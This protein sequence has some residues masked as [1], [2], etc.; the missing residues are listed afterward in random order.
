MSGRSTM[1]LHLAPY[2]FRSRICKDM[3]RMIN[4]KLY[5]N[6]KI[7]DSLSVNDPFALITLGI[8]FL[9]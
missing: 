3:E 6:V 4:S 2:S 9:I 5:H 7:T 1:E 8:A